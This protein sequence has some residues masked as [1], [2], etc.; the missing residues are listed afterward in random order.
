MKLT[1][2]RIEELLCPAGKKDAL[3]FDDEQ[4]GL[5]VR[6]TNSAQQGSLD[7]KFY[8]AQYTVAGQ[9]RRIPLGSC[10]AIKLAAAR[11]A[12][13][14]ILGD[15][16]KDRDP[17]TERKDAAHEAKRKAAHDALTFNALLDQWK[18][19]HLAN[20]RERYAAEAVRAIKSAFAKHLGSPAGD[21][22]R[23]MVVRVLDGLAK[24][25]K[26]AAASATGRYGRACF[27]WAVKRG[28]LEA[29][30]FANLPL[31]PVASRD[32]VLSDDELRAVW[33]ATADL[34]SFNLIV[35]T[36]VLTGQRREEVASMAWDELS[37]DLSTWTIPAARAKNGAAHIVPL[38]AQAQ[39]ILQVVVR[40]AR[41]PNDGGVLVFP[42]EQGVYSGW[43]KS[44]E[45]LDRRSGVS[46]WTL[47]D[48]PRTMATG[49]QKLGVRL[50]VTE[51]VLN[52]LSGSRAGIVGVYQRHEWA[53]EKR[54]ALN[55]WGQRVAS[56]V[57]D[58]EAG[59]NVTEFRV[60]SA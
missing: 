42:G 43:S 47:H 9:K 17:A 28:S 14:V 23:A 1:Q 8:L 40:M 3:V 44:K 45:R 38:S 49:L 16:A 13:K 21:V 33:R 35:R 48:L 19:L 50:E 5:G 29:N 10:S 57:E 55:A 7:A 59:D 26:V 51:A 52:H 31:T 25:G 36:L 34:G 20:K 37:P 32:R 27:Q 24:D 11:D 46:E 4:L 58:R 30:P 54:A 15:V 39:T 41:G 2:R 6:V 53:D 12:V 18:V 22:S 60:R 56:I